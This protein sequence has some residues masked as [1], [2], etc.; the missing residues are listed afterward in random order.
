[1]KAGTLAASAIAIAVAAPATATAQTEV[2]EENRAKAVACLQE[3]L[4]TKT[5]LEPEE[6]SSFADTWVESNAVDG[7][8]GVFLEALG[9]IGELEMDTCLEGWGRKVADLS[10]K[11]EWLGRMAALRFVEA[12]QTSLERYQTKADSE[13]SD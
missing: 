12:I 10:T 5:G 4:A 2:S 11:E 1:M 6:L 3:A 13:A 7:K 9:E 8:A